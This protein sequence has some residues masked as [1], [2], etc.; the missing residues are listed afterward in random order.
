[1]ASMVD[2]L[3]PESL[4][5]RCEFY[6][7]MLEKKVLLVEGLSDE[8]FLKPILHSSVEVLPADGVSNVLQVMGFLEDQTSVRGV[9]DI[10]YEWI[11]HGF[12]WP[13]DSRLCTYDA[14]SL[15]IFA[16]IFDRGF[17]HSF[18]TICCK[19]IGYLRAWNR[20]EN[21]H[22]NFSQS[23]RTRREWFEDSL[24]D[25]RDEDYFLSQLLYKYG[26]EMNTFEH[27]IKPRIDSH[28]QDRPEYLLNGHDLMDFLQIEPEVHPP[29]L[30][31]L[32]MGARFRAS[33]LWRFLNENLLL[34]TS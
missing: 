21:L 3:N 16:F 6:T 32:E 25:N 13:H 9:I 5:L 29:T 24:E 18:A 34:R 22:W 1:M 20:L 11:E 19:H 2:G 31:I 26:V 28:L 27:S 8:R 33:A 14:N 17:P 23:R 10:D 30:S 4:A 7:K 12:E 15:E